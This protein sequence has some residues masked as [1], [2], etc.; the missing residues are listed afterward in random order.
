MIDLQSGRVIS[1][2]LIFVI[3]LSVAALG[4]YIGASNYE[5]VNK[6]KTIFISEPIIYKEK[7]LVLKTDKTIGELGTNLTLPQT[8]VTNGF[9]LNIKANK[10]M[11]SGSQIK[12]I[13]FLSDAKA[14]ISGS[15]GKNGANG[16]NGDGGNGQQGSKGSS[17]LSGQNG[18]D[19]GSILIHAEKLHA[20][21][22]II[23][24]GQSGGNGGTGGNGGFGGDGGLGRSSKSGAGI[25]GIGDCK[26]GPGRGG[27]AGSGGNGGNGGNGGDS[28]KS[29]IVKISVNSIKEG[30]RIF[31]DT[32]S[33]LSG[34]G[35]QGGRGGKAGSPGAEGRSIG[36][37]RPAGRRGAA[38]PNGY[39]GEK[40][41]DGSIVN[42]TE[43][44]LEI[45]EEKLHDVGTIVYP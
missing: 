45:G 6:I 35:G 24:K 25:L 16:R 42:P 23:N 10:L 31:A 1:K 2:L 8:I 39:N 30:V 32:N 3:I 37:C 29:G 9:N 19:A 7:E 26:S 27:T 14:G 38:A 41:I 44:M 4:V 15:T 18:K 13:S 21:I 5:S 17:G 40:G 43:I 33:G 36:F 22:S 34:V 11:S 20:N 12:I 28:G